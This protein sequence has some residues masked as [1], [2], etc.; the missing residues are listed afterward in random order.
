MP[1][2]GPFADALGSRCDG[3][4]LAGDRLWAL[5]PQ[6]S[7]SPICPYFSSDSVGV[8]GEPRLSAKSPR[9]ANQD[10][11]SPELQERADTVTVKLLCG[12][13]SG[14]RTLLPVLCNHLRAEQIRSSQGD[15]NPSSVS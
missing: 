5:A 2:F 8:H 14:Q 4:L 13:R 11:G 10:I 15:S 3:P 6:C 1:A 7:P 9:S 12:F